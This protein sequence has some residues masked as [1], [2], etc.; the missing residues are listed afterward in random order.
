LTALRANANR[1]NILRG[2][3]LNETPAG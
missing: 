1:D 2:L 3:G